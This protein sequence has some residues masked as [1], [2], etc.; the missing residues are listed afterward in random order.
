MKSADLSPLEA[1]LVTAFHELY[2]NHGFP[3]PTKVRVRQRENTGSGRYVDIDAEDRV[4]LEDGSV[5]LGGRFIEMS[6]VPTGLMAVAHIKN[7]RV[8][9][10]EIAVHGDGHWD[11]AERH[12]SIV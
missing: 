8:Q 10:I 11:G 5:D 6:G 3:L 2:G 9:Q 7:H 1:A 4:D 12:W